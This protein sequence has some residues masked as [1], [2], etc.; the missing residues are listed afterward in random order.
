MPET[1]MI[2][3]STITCPVCGTAKVETMPTD[4]CLY[5]YDCTGCHTLLR[6][7]SGDCCVFCSYGSVPCPPIQTA[8]GN[9]L[10]C[11]SE[12]SRAAAEIRPGV[13]RPDWSVVTRPAA[14]DA[15]LARDRTRGSVQEKW[16]HALPAE[17]DTLWRAVLMLFASQGRP[18]SVA[19]IASGTG[20]PTVQVRA[21]LVELQTHDLLGVDQAAD[22]VL[23]AYP[24]TSQPTEHRVGMN[25]RMLNALCAIDALGAGALYQTDTMITSCCRLCGAR[26][27]MRMTQQGAALSHARPA[28]AVVWYD[29]AAGQT[30]AMSCCPSIGFFCSDQHLQQW[31]ATRITA[32]TGCRLAL[33]EALEVGRAIF[34]PV[35]A[36]STGS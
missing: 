16:R 26:I 4:A 9:P 25:G 3:E 33:D 17:Q 27:E 20:L 29:L 2:T 11:Q 23:Y 7:K 14:R 18:P 15:L 31:M 28:G 5:F 1:D 30:A 8:D 34:G 21:L 19:E 24:F 35:L 13:Q 36:D 6:P 32:R 10:C 12:E 22:T